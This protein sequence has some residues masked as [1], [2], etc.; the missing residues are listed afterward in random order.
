M[1]DEEDT[2]HMAADWVTFFQSGRNYDFYLAWT[3][4]RNTRLRSILS[5]LMFCL[6]GSS[7]LRL[8]L[9]NT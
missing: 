3:V 7:I 2:N 4:P 8:S 1:Q 5:K 9:Q 6:G